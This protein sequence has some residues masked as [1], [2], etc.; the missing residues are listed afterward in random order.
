MSIKDD[1]ENLKAVRKEVEIMVDANSKY[2]FSKAV[3]LGKILKSL[4]VI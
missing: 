4:D 2:N 1:E 3:R